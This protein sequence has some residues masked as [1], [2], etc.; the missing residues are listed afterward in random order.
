M[1]A[2]GHVA[3]EVGTLVGGEAGADPGAVH[4]LGGQTVGLATAGQFFDHAVGGPRVERGQA[5]CRIAC[6]AAADPGEF[7]VIEQSLHG[8]GRIADLRGVQGLETRGLLANARAHAL[9]LLT[10]QVRGS[11]TAAHLGPHP[12]SARGCAGRPRHGAAFP[13]PSTAA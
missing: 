10:V 11:A 8:I 13:R 5:A 4:H 3:H 6:F 7:A 1:Q 12:G 9:H 2:H